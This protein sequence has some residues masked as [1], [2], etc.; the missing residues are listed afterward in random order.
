MGGRAAAHAGLR[1]A[2]WGLQTALQGAS[3]LHLP[4]RP[5]SPCARSAIWSAIGQNIASGCP[6]TV[7]Q[8]LMEQSFDSFASTGGRHHSTARGARCAL[9]TCDHAPA[10]AHATGHSPCRCICMHSAQTVLTYS[11]KLNSCGVPEWLPHMAASG[12]ATDA[13]RQLPGTGEPLPGAP[14]GFGW[15]KYARAF[16]MDRHEPRTV[17]RA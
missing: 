3:G 13:G 6:Y 5:L 8:T 17:S 9:R 15:P 16:L 4:C 12:D 11:V 10:H 1:R 14:P 7:D 2:S